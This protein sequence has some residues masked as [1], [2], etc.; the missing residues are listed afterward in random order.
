MLWRSPLCRRPLL[1]PTRPLT[2]RLLHPPL[3]DKHRSWINSD[4]SPLQASSAFQKDAGTERCFLSC[5]LWADGRAVACMPAPALLWSW[6]DQVQNTRDLEVLITNVGSLFCAR[7]RNLLIW[8]LW[9]CLVAGLC[10]EMD[11]EM[12]TGA[13]IPALLIHCP[14]SAGCLWKGDVAHTLS[15]TA[16]V[17]PQKSL[18]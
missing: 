16:S 7:L 11:L 15:S 18:L 10:Y 14:F 2:T 8:E 5:P 6:R 13:L 17:S 3:L 4:R 12:F 1:P 9:V